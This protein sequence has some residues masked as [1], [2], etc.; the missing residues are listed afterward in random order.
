M[1]KLRITQKKSQ[2]GSTKRQ[3]DTLYALGFRKM[4]SSVEV[5]DSPQILGMIRKVNHLVS[6]EKV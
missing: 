1:A 4:N 5:E 6:V 3:K 2:I